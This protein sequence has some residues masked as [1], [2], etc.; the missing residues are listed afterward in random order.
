VTAHRA[1]PL[2]RFQQVSKTFDR[3][4]SWAVR[5][6]TMDLAPGEFLSLL[7]ASGSGKTTSLMMLAGLEPLTSGKL[8]LDGVDLGTL[9]AWRRDIGVVFQSY[10]L[11]PH[12]TV[13]ENLAFP[14]EVRKRPKVEIVER[15]ARALALVRLVGLADRLPK[16]LSGGQQQ[17][18]ALARALVFEPRLVVLDEPLG[19]LDRV[20]R[21]EM[22]AE[23]RRLHRSLGIAMIYV[24]HDQDEALSLS[25]RIAVFEGGRM[26]Q[27]DTPLRLFDAPET[28]SIARFIAQ[29]ALLRGSVERD[30]PDHR[31]RLAGGA[32]LAVAP[33]QTIPHGERAVI[34]LRP[35]QL[36]LTA[37][38]QGALSARL[39]DVTFHGDHHRVSVALCEGA[40]MVVKLGL[41]SRAGG[42]DGL[43]APGSSVGL[44]IVGTQPR[45]WK[46][47]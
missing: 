46:E 24:T 11:F 7:G 25:D 31:V 34:A 22:Q 33:H 30:G 27:V 9:P 12:M 44:A 16:Q 2:V 40:E 32:L 6:L 15:V 42:D 21:A 20:L 14:L 43:P 8:W 39:I 38:G 5:D 18:V 35:D 41:G 29:A 28:P 37:D 26:L 3:G 47:A 1:G 10:A 17:R 36:R 23:I 4:R 45:A 19:A 13:A